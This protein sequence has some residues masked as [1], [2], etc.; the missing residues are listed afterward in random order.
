MCVCVCVCACVYVRA[1]MRACLRARACVCVCLRAR[2]SVYETPHSPL[3]PHP[4]SESAQE[5]QSCRK[6]RFL[7]GISC[8]QCSLVRGISAAA[9]I[10]WLEKGHDPRKIKFIHSFIRS[11]PPPPSSKSLSISLSLS[12]PPSIS[13]PVSYLPSAFC[14]SPPPFFLSLPPLTP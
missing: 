2:M 8:P 10:H 6:W 7:A 12:P 3:S 9:Q 1:C 4:L 5:R 14:P 13:L 11:L